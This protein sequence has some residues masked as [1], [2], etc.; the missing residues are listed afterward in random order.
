MG[1]SPEMI[2]VIPSFVP[3]TLRDR[4]R[5]AP[6]YK[7]LA[8]SMHKHMSSMISP[9][10]CYLKD[11]KHYLER[12]G[13]KIAGNPD[14]C[15]NEDWFHDIKNAVGKEAVQDKNWKFVSFSRHPIERFISGYSN[16]CIDNRKVE[17]L[18]TCYDCVDDLECFVDNLYRDIMGY[19]NGQRI[20]NYE[21]A[22]H[23]YP[24]NYLCNYNL[25]YKRYNIIKY[26][27]DRSQLPRILSEFNDVLKSASV[28]SSSRQFLISQF[29]HTSTRHTTV[30]SSSRKS[31]ESE[32]YNSPHLLKKLYQM[33]YYDFVLFDY[34]IPEDY[35]WDGPTVVEQTIGEV[36]KNLFIVARKKIR[37]HK[38]SQYFNFMENNISP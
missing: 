13:S 10:M 11:E 25:Y 34:D 6:Q 3:I 16:I 38:F 2:G 7:L 19:A 36:A 4:I 27:S 12:Y 14:A 5:V 21:V 1:M 24:Q 32:L 22:A 15:G 8:C 29:N 28:P 30:N 35:Q 31:I 18:Q 20:Q 26:T 33:F 9:A 37:H 17:G 23:F